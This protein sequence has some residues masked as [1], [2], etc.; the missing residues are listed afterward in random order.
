MLFL[1]ILAKDP[2]NKHLCPKAATVKNQAALKSTVNA[3][4][5]DFNVGNSV[6]AQNAKTA[7]KT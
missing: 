5:M 4:R 3:I 2:F 6:I 7:L 1:T